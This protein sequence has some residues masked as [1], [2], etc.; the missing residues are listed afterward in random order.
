MIINDET[1]ANAQATLDYILMNPE[2]HDQS[3]WV[4]QTENFNWD[5]YESQNGYTESNMCGTT[6][7]AAGTILYLKMGMDGLNLGSSFSSH[8]APY[9]GLE[10]VA[11]INAIF[12]NMSEYNVVMQLTALANGDEKKFWDFA[13][14][15]S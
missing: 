6:M 10:N 3:T 14:D 1:K 7:C 2:N 4:G 8:A 9:F 12:L 11:E 15:A 13:E 5:E